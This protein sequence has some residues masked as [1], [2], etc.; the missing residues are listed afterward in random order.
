MFLVKP[1][2]CP[3]LQY[4]NYSREKQFQF[5]VVEKRIKIYHS[6]SNTMLMT[7]SQL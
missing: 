6:V 2:A 3:A 7:L 1:Y 4:G 5:S